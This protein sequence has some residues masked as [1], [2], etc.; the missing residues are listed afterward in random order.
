MDYTYVMHQAQ[1]DRL[2]D[3]GIVQYRPADGLQL[4]LPWRQIHPAPVRHLRAAALA[5]VSLIVR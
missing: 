1:R 2:E 4:R 5:I 3:A